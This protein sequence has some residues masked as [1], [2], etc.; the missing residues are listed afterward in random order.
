M[1][2]SVVGR[3]VPSTRQNAGSVIAV[4]APGGV[5]GPAVTAVADL[6]VTFGMVNA[7]RLAQAVPVDAAGVMTSVRSCANARAR[8][9]TRRRVMK[10]PPRLRL[11]IIGRVG[12]MMSTSLPFTF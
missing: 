3:A 5:K 7:A 9:A 12:Q 6:I 1:S 4:C 10:G 8:A 11:A 2:E